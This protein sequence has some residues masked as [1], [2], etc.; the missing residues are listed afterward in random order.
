MEVYLINQQKKLHKHLENLKS[1]SVM[2]YDKNKLIEK[3][4]AIK[5][6]TTKSLEELN[7]DFFFAYNIFPSDILI[8]KT[9]WNLEHRSM[10]IGDTI[11]QQ[12]F[13]PPNKS[14]SQKVIFGVRIHQIINEENRKGFSYET[15]EGHVEKG[16]STFTIEQVDDELSFKIQTFSTPGNIIT[17]L[18][19]PIITIPYQ[20]YCTKKA[21][22]YVKN[23]LERQ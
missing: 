1:K 19:G 21:L 5:I 12:A 2:K 11:V 6:E 16:I 10:N 23:Q 15:I 13:L 20:T 4:T 18:V 17:K 7:L 9:Q 14:L 3:L 22:A 8:Y